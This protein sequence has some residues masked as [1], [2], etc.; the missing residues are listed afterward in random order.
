MRAFFAL[1]LGFLWL[2]QAS[3]YNVKP[4]PTFHLLEN[5]LFNAKIPEPVYIMENKEK[6]GLSDFSTFE[7]LS[8]SILSLVPCFYITI[9]LLRKFG[10]PK[11]LNLNEKKNEF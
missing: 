7:I 11:I 6:N 5:A 8:Q 4:R 3:G 10:N 2:S 9:F 1:L